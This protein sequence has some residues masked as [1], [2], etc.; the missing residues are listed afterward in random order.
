MA[1][2]N[3]FIKEFQKYKSTFKLT[4]LDDSNNIY[5]CTN[6]T[7]EVIDFDSIIEDKFPDSN[8][9]PKSFDA[10]YIYK[11]LIFCIEF[12]NQK[13]S[14]IDNL[15]VQGKLV[16]GKE[17]LLKLL[18]KYNIQKDNY[19][20]IYCVVYKV[21]KEPINRYKCGIDKNKILF[22]LDIYKKKGFVEDIYTQNVNFFTKEFKKQLEKELM[23]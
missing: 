14:D 9:R 11:N 17:E 18:Q 6:E 5:L 23:C 2:I 3:R 21:C 22:G 13:P 8:I 1:D 4:S 16:D 20:F 15:E 12:K 19:S 7:Q 10:I